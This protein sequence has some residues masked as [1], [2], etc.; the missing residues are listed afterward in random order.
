MVGLVAHR[1]L[2][3]LANQVYY[4]LYD[5]P[6]CPTFGDEVALWWAAAV[7]PHLRLEVMSLPYGR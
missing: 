6:I 1:T 4:C 5:S 2:L 7:I 3:F